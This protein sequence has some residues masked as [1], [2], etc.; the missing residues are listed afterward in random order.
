MGA[1][2][3]RT[4][5]VIVWNRLNRALAPAFW[6]G[7]LSLIAAF[8]PLAAA[9]FDHSA[10]LE[11]ISASPTGSGVTLQVVDPNAGGLVSTQVQSGATFDLLTVSGVAAWSSGPTIYYYV[12]DPLLRRW[13]GASANVG[14]T[15]DLTVASGLVAWTTG[16]TAHYRVYDW[17]RGLWRADLSALS[18]TALS[19]SAIDGVVAVTTTA[20]VVFSAYDPVSGL[21]K[22]SS[23][24]SGSPSDLINIHGVVAWTAGNFVHCQVYDPPRGTWQGTALNAGGNPFDLRS[25]N[26]VVAWT[27][28]PAVGYTVYDPLRGN[29]RSLSEN[30]GYTADLVVSNSTVT[31]S[32]AT[33]FYRRGYN[34]TSGTWA[35]NNALPLAYFAMTTNQ[36]NAPFTVAFIDMSLGAQFWSWDF[37]DGSAVSTRRSP[38]HR[39]TTFGQFLVT[40]TASGVAGISATNRLIT[41]DLARPTGTILINNGAASTT[42]VNVTLQLSAADNSS[43]L[44]SMRFS[45]QVST[46]WSEWEPFA[47]TKAWVLTAGAGSKTVHAQFRDL[48]GNIS[49]DATDSILLDLTPPPVV[50]FVSTNVVE[51]VGL[52]VVTVTLDHTVNRIVSVRYTSLDG[53]AEAGSDYTAVSGLLVFPANTLVQTFEIPVAQDPRVELDETILLMFSNPTNAIIESEGVATIIDD[54]PASVS[55]ATANFNASEDIGNAAIAVRLNAATSRPVS[56]RVRTGMG[57]ATEDSDFVGTNA[58]VT[59]PPGQTNRIVNVQILN[60]AL[61]EFTESVSLSMTNLTNAVFGLPAQATLTIL[62]D[63]M[64]F[65][66]FSATNFGVFENSGVAVITVWL[67]KPFGQEVFADY[68]ALGGSAAP[69]IDYIPSTGTLQFAPTQTNKTFLV[70]LFNDGQVE[71]DETIH[72]TLNNIVGASGGSQLE[73]DIVLYD[74]DGAPRLLAPRWSTNGFNVTVRGSAQQKFSIE[75][76]TNLINWSVLSTLTNTSGIFEFLDPT[77]SSRPYRFYRTT[78]PQ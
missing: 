9:V 43:A 75:A 50:S 53:T 56:V 28:N 47:A 2:C 11:N 6:S 17:T 64:P 35:E 74:D 7:L 72:L 54:D 34:P 8:S 15:F 13:T 31:W 24:N 1:F 10:P 62:D 67:S 52:A 37:G 78:L 16:A 40:E 21:W 4:A 65:V 66:F 61:D 25:V 70:T 33:Q 73:A 76:S 22:K 77:E 68:I 26:S 41:T 39:Y 51:A 14:L 38:R 30:S 12:Y 23:V 5:A 71:P 27:R 3:C 49:L 46:A 32:T 45:N 42:N 19:L 55:F 69:G 20:G 44:I 58:L 18:S 59:F 29:W 36:G 48:A 57:S 60:D 63:D